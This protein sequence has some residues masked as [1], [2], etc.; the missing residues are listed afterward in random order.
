MTKRN[1]GRDGGRGWWKDDFSGTR[2]ADV[3]L[4][5]V[6]DGRPG[7]GGDFASREQGGSR[8]CGRATGRAGSAGGRPRPR[9]KGA[10][11]PGPYPR[12]GRARRSSARGSRPPGRARGRAAAGLPGRCP[13]PGERQRHPPPPSPESLLTWAAP[14]AAPAPRGERRRGGEGRRPSMSKFSSTHKPFLVGRPSQTIL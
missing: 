7:A 8:P 11:G 3:F 4:E 14:A 1:G 10:A 12:R 5:L 6:R 13:A 9:R 2:N